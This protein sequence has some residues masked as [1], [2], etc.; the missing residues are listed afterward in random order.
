MC[1]H[2][3]GRKGL[4][5]RLRGYDGF[6]QVLRPLVRHSR[7]SGNL[8]DVSI[9]VLGAILVLDLGWESALSG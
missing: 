1:F 9:S 8:G 6:V 4:D 2:P 5:T 3:L 7:E